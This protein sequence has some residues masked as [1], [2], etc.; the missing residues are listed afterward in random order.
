MTKEKFLFDDDLLEE[1]HEKEEIEN[2]ILRP[3][4]TWVIFEPDG[5]IILWTVAAISR[6]AWCRFVTPPVP[7]VTD[8]QISKWEMEGYQCRQITI[9]A[10][11]K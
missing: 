4:L 1:I 7:Y 2:R 3:K 10:L 5:E 6:H 8:E 11:K 9:K